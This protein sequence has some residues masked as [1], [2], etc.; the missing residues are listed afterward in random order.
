[1]STPLLEEVAS[2]HGLRARLRLRPRARLMNSKGLLAIMRNVRWSDG[3]LTS[4]GHDRLTLALRVASLGLLASSVI[5]YWW[6][7]S[8]AGWIALMV[9]GVA[10]GLVA[11]TR[12]RT[13]VR[14]IERAGVGVPPP[15]RASSSSRFLEFFARIYERAADR[16]EAR[17]KKAEAHGDEVAAT[18]YRRRAAKER[19]DAARC[20]D[21]LA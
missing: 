6:R 13:L 18:E 16:L 4:H 1:M 8:F 11:S 10:V 5:V 9:A 20:R 12:L 14:R 21:T 2:S 7:S 19:A 17:A 15:H 3:R